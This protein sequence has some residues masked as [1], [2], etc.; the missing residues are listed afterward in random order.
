MSIEKLIYGGDGLARNG[1]D[2]VF[3]PL[4]L[5]GER[6]RV[7][8]VESRPGLH[9]AT[10]DEVLA[11]S[12]DR[13][14]APCQHFGVCGGCHY[15]HA[16]YEAQV[17]IKVDVLREALQRIGKV[18][19][20]ENIEV[21]AGQPLAYRNRA[22][23]H[24]YKGKVG[25]HQLSSRDLAPIASCLVLSPKLSEAYA[26]LRR[27]STDRRFPNF[28]RSI[29]LFTDEKKVQ[30]NV[31]TTDRPVAKGFFDWCAKEIPGLVSGALDYQTGE[32]NYRVSHNAFFQVN[33]FLIEP[34]V[35]AALG[36]A[37]GGRALDLFAGVGLFSLPLSQ[38]SE[39]VS[40]VESGN[41]AW[42][43]LIFNAERAGCKVHGFKASAED[44][45]RDNPGKFDFVLADPPRTGLGKQVTSHLLASRPASLT[46]VSC[47]PATLARDLAA[48]SAGYRIERIT[49]VDLFPQTFH[50]ETVTQLTAI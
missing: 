21:I 17:R 33:R 22:Q 44:Y 15:Q 34:L 36:G 27:M 2:V 49:L 42:R 30:L 12:P 24:F 38:R 9:R 50:L 7:S 40:A 3:V 4:T 47:D 32:F 35:R 20:P 45:L 39:E 1:S 37:K 28:V 13:Q 46:I 8:T 5:P 31:L 48:L 6:L 14:P 41:S 29:E 23:F 11:P 19:A 43:D 10:I 16:T 25:F 18:Q 26:A